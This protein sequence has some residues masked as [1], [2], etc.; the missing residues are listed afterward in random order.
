DYD[1]ALD[2][3][4]KSL[5]I[6]Q[7][8]GDKSGEGTTLNNIS[9]IYDARGDYD[10]A[11][12]YLKKS[13]KIRQEIGDKSGEIATR[14]NIAMMAMDKGDI[15]TYAQEENAAYQLA[16]QTGDAY[17][18]FQVGRIWGQVLYQNGVKEDGLAI[19]QQAYQIGTRSGLPGTTELEHLL[20]QI[21]GL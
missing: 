13:L 12:D 7:E 19:L 3:L 14:H 5:K 16:L 8:I 20:R 6:R 9:Q 10:T 18:A 17:G 11:L 1:T 21:G 2:Y 4:K 15:Q